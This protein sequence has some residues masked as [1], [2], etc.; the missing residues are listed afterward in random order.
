MPESVTDRPTRSHEY[1]FLLTKS[2]R[3][4]Y[5]A[6]AIREPVNPWRANRS[7]DDARNHIEARKHDSTAVVTQRNAQKPSASMRQI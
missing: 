6:D 5:D 4:F 1:I 2:E 7:R 3:Y